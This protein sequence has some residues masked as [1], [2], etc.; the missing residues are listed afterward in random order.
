MSIEQNDYE[1]IIL[2]FKENVE[3]YINELK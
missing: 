1:S 3:G 2:V